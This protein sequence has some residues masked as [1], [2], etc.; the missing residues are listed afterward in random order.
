MNRE[1]QAHEDE[2][3]G[4]ADGNSEKNS[5]ENRMSFWQEL[6]AFL[7]YLFSEHWIGLTVLALAICCVFVYL[8]T[9]NLNPL[10]W[11]CIG[12][13]LFVDLILFAAFAVAVKRST[14]GTPMASPV[15]RLQQSRQRQC[16]RQN[17][18]KAPMLSPHRLIIHRQDRPR[19]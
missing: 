5:T 17:P 2:P 14:A 7:N 4:K 15:P 3:S 1:V 8:A 6:H 9:I 11:A 10:W 12:T 16:R 19:C 18:K 13:I